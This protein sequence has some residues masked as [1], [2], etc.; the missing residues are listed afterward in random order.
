MLTPS[1]EM[2]RVIIALAAAH[3]LD[4]S[5]VGAA[6]TLYNEPF[7]RLAVEVIAPNQV[8]VAHYYE[9]NGDLIADPDVVFSVRPRGWLPCA[10]YHPLGGDEYDPQDAQHRT[11]ESQRKLADFCDLWARNIE[12]QGYIA[13]GRRSEEAAAPAAV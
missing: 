7:M 2:Q 11:L 13:R 6:L 3:G 12:S 9:Q 1:P 8:S 4:L 10:F 5:A